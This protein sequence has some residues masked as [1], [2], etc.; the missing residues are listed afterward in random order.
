M[1]NKLFKNKFILSKMYITLFVGFL[2]GS[3]FL[4]TSSQVQDTDILQQVYA[5]TIRQVLYAF[6]GFTIMIIGVLGKEVIF[7]WHNRYEPDPLDDERGWLLYGLLALFGARI[8]GGL[9]TSIPMDSIYNIS[10]NKLY[11]LSIALTSAIFEEWI[12]CGLS[13]FLFVI[14]KKILKDEFKSIII[15]TAIVAGLFALFHVGVL[16]FTLPAMLYLGAGRVVYTYVFLKTRTLL[17]STFAHLGHNFLVVFMG[18]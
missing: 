14:I 15:S 18:V 6:V 16:G 12:F 1:S 2:I 7:D 13:I 10:T 8:L 9:V 3:L 11:N 4:M 17:T 5:I